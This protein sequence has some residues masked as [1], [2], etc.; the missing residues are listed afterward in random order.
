MNLIT[1]LLDLNTDG[2]QLIVQ[3]RYVKKG[4]AKIPKTRPYMSI[5]LWERLRDEIIYAISL[6]LLKFA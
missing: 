2:T 1:T 4:K 5:F 3:L 6:S